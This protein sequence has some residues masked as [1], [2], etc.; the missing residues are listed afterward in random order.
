[1]SDTERLRKGVIAGIATYLAWGL[2]TIYWKQLRR[3]DAFEIIGWRIIMSAV[4]MTIV[5]TATRRW[6]HFRPVL[7]QP[8][9][10][11][12]V[13]VAAVLL[14]V[15]WTS[16]VW[17]VVH[18][19]VM[20]TALGYF[21]APLG[22][23]TV[24]VLVLHERLRRAQWVAIVFGAAAVAVLT[25]SYGRVPWIALA[26]AGSWTG[27][28]YLKKQ[29]PL[30]PVESMAA[31]SVVLLVPAIVMVTLLSGKATSVVSSATGGHVMLLSLSGVVTIF[32]LMAFAY[33]AHR[34]PLTV[35]GPM[36]YSVPSINFLLGWL[37]YH[38]ALPPS[39][40]VGF[41]LVWI[42]LVVLTVDSAR[43][44]RTTRVV[45]QP[46]LA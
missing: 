18:D 19:R 30:T 36:Q 12:R 31:E 2:L 5:L 29:V 10:L 4:V 40:V 17:A 27:Y 41:L 7:R 37:A 43:R 39:R 21:I 45:P 13:T 14:T 8:A 11:V 35:L 42:G 1:M 20:E 33:A 25:A 3:F 32:P 28:G 44:A 34:V 46:V 9:L 24:G 22:T 23:M 6:T 38:E 26:I 16:Y 15:N